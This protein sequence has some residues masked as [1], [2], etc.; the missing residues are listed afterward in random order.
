MMK[1]DT[2]LQAQVDAQLMEQGAF[3]ALDLLIHS[4]RLM[5]SD[6]ESWRRGELEALDT[7]LMGNLDKIRAH[8]EQ[9]ATYARSIGLVE[10]IQELYPW[11]TQ[12]RSPRP[13]RISADAQLHRLLAGRYAPGQNAPQMDLFFDNPV[14]ALTNGLVQ[15]LCARNIAESQRQLDRLYAHAP[16]HTDLPAFDQLLAALT[17][18]DLTIEDTQAELAFLLDVTP[19]A[20]RLLG[21]QAR[22]L[23]SPLWRQLA[24]ALAS[25]P[26]A[27]ERAELHASFAL[28]QAQDW[29]GAVD[30]VLNEPQWWC[31]PALCL[32]LAQSGFYRQRRIEGL[33]AWCYMCWQAPQ[34]AAEVLDKRLQPD[35]SLTGLW[36]QF[37]ELEEEAVDAEPALTA[38][39]FPAWMLLREP[40]LAQQLA[41]DLPKGDSPGEQHY[42]CVHR[43]V[44]ARRANR[45]SDEMQLRR[46]LQADRPALFRYLKTQL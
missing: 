35:S 12:E 27:P 3:S 25:N 15:A 23:L 31:H 30:C 13:L 8:I 40:G 38:A 1:I 37:M 29:A 5:Y 41:E 22:D 36:R 7:V 34:Q 4:G 46:T 26:F 11:Q 18:L 33:T 17:H 14:V 9:A 39:D 45:Q 28:V 19:A 10:Q 16:N 2:E 21:G 32:R 6:Y 44:Q 20:K 24:V 42:R 43:L